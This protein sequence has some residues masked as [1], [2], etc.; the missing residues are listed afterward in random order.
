MQVVQGIAN[1][2]PGERPLEVVPPLA[3][4]VS[5]G[6]G[7]T[8]VRRRL[9]LFAQ[10][11]LTHVALSQ[12][13][14]ARVLDGTLLAQAVAPGVVD[15]FDVALAR[16]RRVTELFIGAGHALTQDGEDIELAYPLR[17]DPDAI[18][19]HGSSL[20]GW[21]VPADGS[22]HTRAGAG[23]TIALAE[24]L[25]NAGDTT[26]ALL[27]PGLLPHALVLVAQPVAVAITATDSTVAAAQNATDEVL[28]DDLVWEDGFRL[29]WVAWPAD[30]P[31]PPWSANGTDLDTR[32]RN[33]LAYA[34]YDE[35]RRPADLPGTRSVRRMTEPRTADDP[36][37]PR[38]RGEPP[39]PPLQQPWPWETLGVALSIVGFDGGFRPAFADRAAVVRQGGGR[40]NRAP[41]IPMAGD[42]V[43]WQARVS[44]MMEQL[45]ELEPEQR[46]A[47]RLARHFDRLPPAG[48]LPL[49][50]VN[51][52]TRRQTFFPPQF[53]VQVQPVPLDLVDTLLAESASL[54]PLNVDAHEQVQM[55]VPVPARYYDPDLLNLDERINPLFDLEIG[56]LET[57]RLALL[58]RR[59]ALRRRVDLLAKSISGQWP[60]Y[61]EDDPNA[62]PE[63][64]GALDGM[65][66][67]RVRLVQVVNPNTWHWHGFSTAQA[68]LTLTDAHALMVFVQV[69]SAVKSIALRVRLAGGVVAGFVWGERSSTDTQS[70]T[71]QLTLAGPLPTDS[72][73]RPLT[74]QWMRL[75]APVSLLGRNA[76]GQLIT[77]PLVGVPL[78]NLEFG[79]QSSAAGGVAVTWGYAGSVLGGTESY[80][81][82]DAWPMGADAKDTIKYWRDDVSGVTEDENHAWGV[83]VDA[84]RV[85]YKIDDITAL[86]DLATALPG[87]LMRELGPTTSGQTKWKRP[88]WVS[89]AGKPEERRREAVDID[90]VL[91]PL[92]EQGL[93]TLIDRLARL[94]AGADDHVEVGFLRSRTDVFRLRQGVL[95]NTLASR[96]L[97]SPSA[98]DLVQRSESATVSDTV[99]ADYFARV[100]ARS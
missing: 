56:R 32:F 12:E 84:T 73:G 89:N 10:R 22:L 26:R 79:V 11:A 19:V 1:P 8:A 75:T 49:E 67:A 13:Q 24:F 88:A 97:T 71:Q 91:P 64:R 34:I 42:D 62:L 37:A 36:P 29:L 21:T 63:E 52:F 87:G 66:F 9:N 46:R 25:Q 17:L 44:Q 96:L 99:F 83:S 31:L 27:R 61:T 54:A 60:S 95:G 3:P 98:A 7:S 33:R 50:T 5:A 41:L 85:T 82:A 45:S 70:L 57:E 80:W 77:N 20:A 94:I 16:S 92:V 53:D 78:D 48:V 6:S 81:V 30:R 35:E 55:L 47:S 100:S 86:Q 69:N 59:D 93:D 40:R 39:P 68:R 4:Y 58:R 28:S 14:G 72:A 15:G 76:S 74:N 2:L 43:L 90:I 38:R 65:A 51:F 18:P 23:E